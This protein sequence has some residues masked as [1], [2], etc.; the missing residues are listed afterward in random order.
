MQPQALDQLIDQLQR[1]TT[2]TEIAFTSSAPVIGPLLVAL[3]R[4]AY[5]LSAR[6][7]LKYYAQQQLEF[8][9]TLLGLL[10]QMQHEL[11]EANA[12]LITLEQANARNTTLHEAY[13][14]D[15]EMLA[16]QSLRH[17]E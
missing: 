3:R 13:N 14:R 7:A 9:R 1:Q 4:A 12:R 8:Q 15:I 16:K 6:W 2:M 11:N 17:N 10:R 5:N